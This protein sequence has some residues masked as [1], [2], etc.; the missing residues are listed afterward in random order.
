MIFNLS[1]G[2]Y[3]GIDSIVEMLIIVVSFIIFYYSKKIYK[4]SN[5]KAYRYFSWAFLFVGISFIFKIF[6]NFTIFYRVTITSSNLVL[7]IINPIKYMALIN[8]ICFTL[9]KVFHL[10]GFLI[11][12]LIVTKTIN[13]EKIFLFLY[14]SLL[15]VFL[16]IF[17][18]FIF[19]ITVFMLLLFL[20]YYF[21][22]NNKKIHTK[23]SSYVLFSFL[24]ILTSH[25]L[26][27]FSDIHIL[28]YIIGEILLLIGFSGL[29]INQIRLKANKG[30][31]CKNE[32]K[33]NKVRSNKRS[34][35]YLKRK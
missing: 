29:L 2:R 33:K 10:I 27:I 19:H 6:T 18:N 7:F 34:F 30:D 11:L 25:L 35:S 8:F 23:N 17:F 26:F 31:F 20:C 22:E 28:F 21:Y 3:Y 24:I 15:V 16:S 12:F 32:I 1:L 9:F 14:F 13:K 4:I 5:E